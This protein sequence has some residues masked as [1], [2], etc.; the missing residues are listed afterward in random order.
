MS[1]R[2]NP[3]KRRPVA[4]TVRRV[5]ECGNRLAVRWPDAP[6]DQWDTATC[7]QDYDHA[8]KYDTP[9]ND[10]SGTTWRILS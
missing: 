10:G 9:C 1:S 6:V 4:P 3:P 5:E 8:R 2:R 7:I